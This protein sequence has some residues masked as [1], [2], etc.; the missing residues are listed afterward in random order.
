MV[1][2]RG[3]GKKLCVCVCLHTHVGRSFV[4]GVQDSTLAQDLCWQQDLILYAGLDF[5]NT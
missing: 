4:L 1:V 3:G 5:A 2:G